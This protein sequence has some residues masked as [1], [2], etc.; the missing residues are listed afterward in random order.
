MY[1]VSGILGS[2]NSTD[3]LHF[4]AK[5]K[6][7]HKIT[8]NEMKK[9][10]ESVHDMKLKMWKSLWFKGKGRNHMSIS[11]EPSSALDIF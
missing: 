7:T 9:K 3:Y 6:K 1:L 4:V 2:N 10:K 8:R 5:E 11:F